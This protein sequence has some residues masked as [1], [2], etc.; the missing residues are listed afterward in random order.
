M[1][2]SGPLDGLI[3]DNR[4]N[5][6]GAS[7]VLEPIMGLFVQGQQGFFVTRQE[8]EP[9]EIVAEDVGGS[10]S[11]PLVVLVDVHTAS[12]GEV[13]SGVLQA[14]ERATVVGQVT[15][16]NV[17]ILRAYGFE[18]GSRA[19]IARWVFQYPGQPLGAWE[20]T[21]IVPDLVVGAPWHTFTE[22]ND[23]ALAAA[24]DLLSP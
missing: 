19:W 22:A 2:R 24:V 8:A 1:A 9:L 13:L 12:F 5:R 15:P 21:G 23:P 3:L 20:E 6:G 7:T 14:S 4:Q 10:Q 16:G 18:D 17:E 11:V